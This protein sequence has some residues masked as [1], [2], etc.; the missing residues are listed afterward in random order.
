[1]WRSLIE[2]RAWAIAALAVPMIGCVAPI[3]PFETS[4]SMRLAKQ[5]LTV[6]TPRPGQKKMTVLAGPAEIYYMYR[7]NRD[8]DRYPR[9]FLTKAGQLFYRD[10]DE[11][12]VWVNPPRQGIQVPAEEALPYERFEGYDNQPDGD[13]LSQIAAGESRG[14]SA[15]RE[16]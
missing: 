11:R 9:Y 16:P 14:E 10:R 1:M 8:L 3:V 6:D 13:D 2:S 5:P 12:A 4:R 7:K 15:N